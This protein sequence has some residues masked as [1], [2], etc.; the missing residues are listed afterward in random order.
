MK[1]KSFFVNNWPIVAIFLLV[2]TLFATNYKAG[3][4]LTGWD[5]LHPEFDFGTNIRRSVFA[6]WQEYQGLGLLGGMGHAA[7]LVRELILYAF[8]FIL[9]PSLL[10]YCWTFLMLFIG[11]TGAY[12]LIKNVTLERSDRVSLKDSIGR[13]GDLQNDK[14]IVPFLG[15]VFYILNLATVQNFYVPFEAFITH[16]AFLPWLLFA[17]INYFL[18]PSRRNLILLSIVLFLATPG[19]YIP[20]LFVVYLLAISILLFV[21][22]FKSSSIEKLKRLIKLYLII[23]I[24]N[25]FWLLPF[26]YFTFTSSSVTLNA[27]INQMATETIFLQNKEFGNITDVMQLKGFL[28]NN[29]DP[30]TNGI[31]TYMLPSWREHLKNPLI[32]FLS[33][34]FFAVILIGCVYCLKKRKAILMAFLLLFVFSFTMLITSTLPFSE[35]NILFRKLPLFDQAF[36]FPFTKFSI[37]ASLA[38][39]IFF[40]IAVGLIGDLAQN[41]F[42]KGKVIIYM[43]FISLLIIIVFPAFKGDL[44]YSKEKLS[45]PKEYFELFDFFKKQDQNTRIAN[46]PQYT[47][48]GWNFYRWGY[49]GSGFLW[50]GIKQPILDR[51]FDVWS[52]NSENYYFEISNALYTKDPILLEK[53]LNKYQI[54]FLLIDKNIFNPPSPKALFIPETEELLSQTSSINKVATFG[55]L[56]IFKVNLKDKPDDFVFLDYNLSQ[57]NSYDWGNYDKAYTDYGNYISRPEYDRP[58]VETSYYPFRSLFSNKT[59]EKIE[60]NVRENDNSIE[61]TKA[62][63]VLNKTVLK[64]PSIVKTEKIIPVDIYVKKNNENT[65]IVNAIFKTPEVSINNNKLWGDIIERSIFIISPELSDFFNLDINGVSTFKIDSK[66]AFDENEYLGTTFL[67]IN[68]DNVLVLS[69]DKSNFLGT[70]V[71]TSSYIK[72]LPIFDEKQLEVLDTQNP[73]IFSIKIPKI[74]DSYLNFEPQIDDPNNNVLNCDNF[75]K[76]DLFSSKENGYLLLSSKNATPCISY[77]APKLFHE[78]GYLIFIKSKNIKGRSLHFW[79]LNEDEKFSPIDTYLPLDKNDAVSVYAVSPQDQFGKSYSFHFDNI[80]IQQETTNILGKLS[81]YPI[82]YN[83]L[84]SIV[85]VNKEKEVLKTTNTVNTIDVSHPNESLYKVNIKNGAMNNPVLILSQSFDPGWKAYEVENGKWKVEN[86]IK[87]SFPFIFGKE[88]KEHVLVNNWE[89]GWLILNSQLVIIFWPQYLEYAGFGFLAATF[90]FLAV[91][92]KK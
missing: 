25:A 18:K 77:Y 84:T 70:V 50:Y 21:L 3:T 9:P 31:F 81:V 60:F 68:Q 15:G 66:L 89:N 6:V 4:W 51:A 1:I 33:F 56:E 34:L 88:I 69:D 64:V 39:A 19:A 13:L 32:N 14:K 82:P 73:K 59:Q 24:V 40:S 43:L 86:W 57:F 20:T 49:G 72:T 27:K 12:Y 53:V 38:Y 41:Y 30:D 10:R 78:Q 22:F 79:M 91:K 55:N 8:S 87:I 85:A 23:F 75:R 7:A 61:F 16:F 42:K 67:T 26:L 11:G 80:S 29:V 83:F 90:L 52:K 62:L 28:F 47:F 35:I 92:I 65:L 44:L 45:I 5:N 46:F 48:W 63:P 17:S 74:K 36:R 2:A 76:G 71:I 58:L 54:N 37:L